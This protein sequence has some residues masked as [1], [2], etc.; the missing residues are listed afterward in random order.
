MR[1][2]VS[3]VAIVL[4]L[5]LPRASHAGALLTNLE[6][7]DPIQ[8][9][10]E[11]QRQAA[12]SLGEAHDHLDAGRFAAARAAL[13]RVEAAPALA[14]YTELLHIHLL[15]KQGKPA[16]AHA[17]ASRALAA[18]TAGTSAA[19]RA[20]LGVVQGEALAQA[21]DAAGAELAWSEPARVTR[22]RG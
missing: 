5:A 15:I 19:L 1:H 2:V 8:R 14:G 12:R 10:S 20:A 16:E 11:D 18:A 13:A 7:A 6:V 4:V 9:L 21:G 3:I 17:R 22:R